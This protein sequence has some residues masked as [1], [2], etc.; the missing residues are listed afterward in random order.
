MAIFRLFASEKLCPI[1]DLF[2][3][4]GNCLW[5]RTA[6][7]RSE[8]PVWFVVVCPKFNLPVLYFQDY[9]LVIEHI[10]AMENGW[11]WFMFRWLSRYTLGNFWADFR[12]FQEYS[13][14]CIVIPCYSRIPVV[15]WQDQHTGSAEVSARL[16]VDPE[17]GRRACAHWRWSSWGLNAI[18]R[19]LIGYMGMDQYLW[20]PFLVGWTSINP[21]YFDVNYR[22]TIGFDTAIWL[23]WNIFPWLLMIRI[24]SIGIYYDHL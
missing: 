18:F 2:K 24:C 12:I 20:V 11:K 19:F 7:Q 10:R 9:L 13:L 6:S 15:F 17:D 16:L 1:P 22:G 5:L 23:N 3:G 8:V 4:L 14:S 21:S